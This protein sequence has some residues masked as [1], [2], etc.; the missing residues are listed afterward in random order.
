MV[1]RGGRLTTFTPD[2]VT[3]PQIAKLID[4]S[5]LRPELIQDDVREGCA[6]AARYDVA[7][8]CV[9]P[10][11]VIGAANL[12]RDTDVLVGTVI[13]FPHGSTT[14]QIKAAETALAVNHGAAEVDLVLNIGW[15][16]S[17]HL[18]EVEADIHAVV[19]AAN[20]ATVKVILENAYLTPE[21]IVAGCHTVERAGAQFVKTS[22]GFASGGATMADLALMRSAVSPAIQV[23]A[24]GGVRSLDVLL[25]MANIGVT[26]FGATATAVILDDLTHRQ[27]YGQP[28]GQAS[29]ATATGGY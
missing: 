29:T 8:V 14:T 18:T 5:L 12:L 15:L 9:R 17:G 28:A 4:H 6:L 23:K 24:A 20:G 22:T 16:R 2:T 10:S 25:A 19:E 26:R 1:D 21:Q 13:G 7:S 3:V 11:D 27:K